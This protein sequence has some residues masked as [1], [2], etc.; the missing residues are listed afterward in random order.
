MPN[1]S[2]ELVVVVDV[3]VIGTSYNFKL[4]AESVALAVNFWL[5]TVAR[6][7]DALQVDQSPTV[8]GVAIT[9]DPDPTRTSTCFTA[10]PLLSEAIPLTFNVPAGTVEDDVGVITAT[11]GGI[12]STKIDISAQALLPAIS[13]ALA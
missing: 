1:L 6:L 3:T 13:V 9:Y 10:P 5:P 2:S 8:L 11:E 7:R 12:T 4:P